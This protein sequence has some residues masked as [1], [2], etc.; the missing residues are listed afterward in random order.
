MSRELPVDP[1]SSAYI[2]SI[3]A[4][5]NRFLHADFGGGG[6]YGIPYR[7]VSSTQRRVPIRFDAYGSRE[8]P[9]PPTPSP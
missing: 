8:R 3:N 7:V 4:G 6:Q 2:A 9:R 1:R 5:G